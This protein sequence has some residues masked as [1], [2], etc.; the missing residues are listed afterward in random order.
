MVAVKL[1]DRDSIDSDPYMKNALLAEVRIMKE[2]NSENTVHL[3]E[4]MESTHNYY[5][6]QE[7]C[8]GDLSG[9][10]K[11]APNHVL[12]EKHAVKLLTDI[13][14]GFLTMVRKGIIHR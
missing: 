14:N 6:I 5:V 3:Y 11:R 7:L 13:C 8:D 9:L 12:E 2:V 10:L 1:I 4:V